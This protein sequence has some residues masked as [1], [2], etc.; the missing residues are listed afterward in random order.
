M[1]VSIYT[2]NLEMNERLENYVDKKI[3]RLDR[4]LPNIIEVRIDLSNESRRQGGDQPV[5]QLTVRN[6]RGKILR[7]EEKK[8]SDIFA[9]FDSAMDKMYRQIRRYKG[10]RRRRAQGQ[11]PYFEIEPE[12]ESAEPVPLDEQE[13][14][15][16]VSSS[17]ISRRKNFQMTPMNEE[18]A[19]EQ[20]ELL[21]H[22]FFVFFNAVT[23]TINV[24]YRREEGDYGILVPETV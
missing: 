21:E 1:E 6:A 14:I 20:M 12:L 3:D 9:A 4:Y 17:Q 7:A 16:D 8:E 24:L 10:R 13:E 18:E 2:R 19:I 11:K 5:A 23:N 15:A 22:D